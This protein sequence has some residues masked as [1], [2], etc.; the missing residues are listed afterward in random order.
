[1]QDRN[2]GQMYRTAI[3]SVDSYEEGVLTGRLYHPFNE[4]GC[5]FHS[6]IQLLFEMERVLNE[7]SFPQSFSAPRKFSN[8]NAPPQLPPLYDG[9]VEGKRATFSVSVLFRQNASWQGS[10]RWIDGEREESFRSVL[11]LIFL[12]DSV[13]T[14]VSRCAV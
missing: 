5:V 7:M 2:F 3:V 4:G 11:E 12:M 13:L 14:G 10:V 9:L 1:M 6:T 8:A